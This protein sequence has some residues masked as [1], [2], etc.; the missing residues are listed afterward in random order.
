[1]P[2]CGAVLRLAIHAN[3]P[4]SSWLSS[5]LFRG[6]GA[7]IHDFLLSVVESNGVDHLT[8]SGGDEAE[9]LSFTKAGGWLRDGPYNGLALKVLQVEICPLFNP[10]ENQRVRCAEVPWVKLSGTT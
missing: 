1:M 4:A 10:V 3:R 7:A 5:D 8:K 2:S 9:C 6:S